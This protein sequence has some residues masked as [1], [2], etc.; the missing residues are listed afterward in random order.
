MLYVQQY[1]HLAHHLINEMP[2][3]LT[4]IVKLGWN[5]LDHTR[6]AALRTS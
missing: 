6:A 4:V 5:F 2:H 3:L 1:I